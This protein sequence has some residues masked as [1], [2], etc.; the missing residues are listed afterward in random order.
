M[1]LTLHPCCV[2][3]AVLQSP[4]RPPLPWGWGGLSGRAGLGRA[5]GLQ[6]LLPQACGAPSCSG[7]SLFP[8]SVFPQET[9]QQKL[10]LMILCACGHS[11]HGSAKQRGSWTFSRAPWQPHAET[12]AHCPSRPVTDR[13][14]RGHGVGIMTGTPPP[15]AD[16]LRDSSSHVLGQLWACVPATLHTP[17]RSRVNVHSEK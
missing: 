2:V 5:R 1:R 7:S 6:T 3:E 14:D 10:E 12:T 17:L 4:R 13:P 16:A 11:W 15:R 9:G 8:L